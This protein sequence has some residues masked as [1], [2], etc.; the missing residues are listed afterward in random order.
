MGKSKDNIKHLI[1]IRSKWK[2]SSTTV[3]IRVP[4]VL[5]EAILEYAKQL[6]EDYVKT[7]NTTA[8]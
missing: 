5:K 3:P 8:Q 7:E 1:P 2:S 4:D 6:D